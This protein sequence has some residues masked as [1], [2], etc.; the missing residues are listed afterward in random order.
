MQNF[1]LS[2]CHCFRKIDTT[3]CE[4]RNNMDKRN[5]TGNEELE[6]KFWKF[7]SVNPESSN[8]N[9]HTQR[10]NQSNNKVRKKFS[11]VKIEQ[12]TLL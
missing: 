3:N 2:N 7:Y 9:E 12:S 5:V 10:L 8:T 1:A 4:A 6:S 11:W